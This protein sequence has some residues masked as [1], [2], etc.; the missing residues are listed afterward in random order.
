M[1]DVS[2]LLVW[3]IISCVFRL[4]IT[5]YFSLIQLQQLDVTFL[6]SSSAFTSQGEF[7]SFAALQDT[8]AYAVLKDSMGRAGTTST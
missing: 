3:S 4:S 6:S 2:F 8:I 7:R 5:P 1:T